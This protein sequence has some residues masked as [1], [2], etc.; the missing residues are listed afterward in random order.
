MST[1]SS[2]VKIDI[3]SHIRYDKKRQKESGKMYK[4]LIELRQKYGYTH[5]FM[6]EQLG[7][8]KSYYWQIEHREKRLY[9]E[10]ALKIAKIF[11]LKPDDLFYD[12]TK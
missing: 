8:C 10:M 7:I 3:L 4:K 9:Y 1:Q 12:E 6:A 11:R 2:L 5:Q